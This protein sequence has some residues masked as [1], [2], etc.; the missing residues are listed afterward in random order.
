MGW[1]YKRTKRTAREELRA[2]VEDQSYYPNGFDHPPVPSYYRLLDLAI[3]ARKEAYMAVLDTR[4]GKV[5]AWVFLIDTRTGKDGLNYGQKEMTETMLPYF[6]RCPTRILDRLSP[7]DD[8]YEPG[9]PSASSATEWR[10]ACR[11]TASRKVVLRDLPDGARIRLDKPLPFADGVSRDVF[12]VRLQNRKR[13]FIG[14][15]GAC[16]RISGFHGI[17]FERIA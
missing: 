2:Y 7:V 5:R 15:D 13:R 9:S 4:D 3:V 12:T 10:D 8:C 14:E 17:L 16:C 11:K 6:F 1:T